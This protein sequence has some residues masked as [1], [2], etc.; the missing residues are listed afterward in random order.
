MIDVVV[1]G[2]GYVGI[3]VAVEFARVGMSV[4]GI[5]IVVDK[6]EKINRG[7]YPLK[8]K[9]PELPDLLESVVS[10]GRLRATTDY[11]PCSEAKNIIVAVETPFDK[12]ALSPNYTALR[13]AMTDIGRRL[14]RNTLVVIE[15]TIAPLTTNN[16]ARKIL[17]KESGLIAGRD[18]YLAHCPERL[19][20]GRLLRNL[21]EYDRVIGGIDPESTRR[22]MELYSKIC[23]GKLHPTNALTAEIVKTVE[24][25]Y[26]DVQIAFANEVAL[27]C[28]HLGV[29]AY[30]VRALVN[31]C[32]YRDMHV[33]GAGVGGHCIPKDL[34][35]LVYGVREKFDPLL[36]KTARKINDYMPVHV[37]ELVI[38]MLREEVSPLCN[39]K[40]CVLGAAF[41][42]NSDDTRNS[43]SEGLINAL[44]AEGVNVVVHDP[45]VGEFMGMAVEKDVYESLRGADCLVL[46]TAHEE[47]KS[48]DMERVAKVMR[49]K[50]IVDGR[51]FFDDGLCKSLG[52]K[53]K[54]V[55]KG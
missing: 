1:V 46:M 41:I 53:Y 4:V 12:D 43:P 54:G 32:P 22:A 3:P 2:M 33:P 38:S 50:I 45:Y 13:S 26:R 31:T 37:A 55:G 34:W 15:S 44:R 10:S 6:V 39:A 29:N 51:N 20:V 23:K 21:R 30:E 8:G 47:Y 19:M 48:M 52:F 49:R 40:V 14:K 18:F 9:E 7:E 24:N 27:I 36:I 5:D 16:L 17:E 28:E 42:E 35:L 25:T 11:S